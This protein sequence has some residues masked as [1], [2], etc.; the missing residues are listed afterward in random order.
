MSPPTDST[1]SAI[2]CRGAARRAL[3]QQVLEEVAGTGEGVGLVARAGAHPEAD[4]GR[5]QGR[6]ATRSRPEVPSRGARRGCAPARSSGLLRHAGDSRVEGCRLS[7]GRRRPPR[8]PPRRHRRHRRRHRCARRLPPSSGPRS[9]NS[10]RAV[11]SQDVLER[12]DL[13]AGSPL[14]PPTAAARDRLTVAVA[15]STPA[16]RR[17]P[18]G[19]RR[20]PPPVPSRRRRRRARARACRSCRCRRRAR[21]P[22]RRG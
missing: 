14:P 1:C 17:S 5:P 7:V 22:R 15:G 3:E 21:A 19:H 9:P 13:A 4:R 2:S 20:S 16:R 10:L 12:H 8:R 11:S 6:A 18:L